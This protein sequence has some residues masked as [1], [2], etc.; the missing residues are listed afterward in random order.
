MW[1]GLPEK[2]VVPLPAKDELRLPIDLVL[3][4]LSR[5][6]VNS[7]RYQTCYQEAVSEGLDLR[8]RVPTPTYMSE[9]AN[10]R[11]NMNASVNN[12]QP[13]APEQRQPVRFAG[14]CFYCGIIGHRSRDCGLIEEDVKKG[15]ISVSSGRVTYPNGQKVTGPLGV[16]KSAIVAEH[17]KNQGAP[18]PATVRNTHVFEVD[19]DEGFF[20]VDDRCFEVDENDLNNLHNPA[21]SDR[22]VVHRVNVMQ[23]EFEDKRYNRLAS[24]VVESYGANMHKKGRPNR[25]TGFANGPKGKP[26]AFTDKFGQFNNKRTGANSV[27]INRPP[28]S[29]ASYKPA[30]SAASYKPVA[31]ATA[32]KPMSAQNPLQAKMLEDH[33]LDTTIPPMDVKM[34]SLIHI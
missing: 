29:A 32:N 10:Y 7:L 2:P 14:T 24:K 16:C 1:G 17:Y 30:A 12:T 8:G 22:D 20:D 34:L 23:G 9:V 21:S 11:P 4:K 25:P 33:K 6:S 31:P 18:A 19:L 28:A 13:L 27:P 15:W 26:A 5:L 3:D